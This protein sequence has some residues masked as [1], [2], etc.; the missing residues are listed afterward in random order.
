MNKTPNT[1]T[2]TALLNSLGY[3]VTVGS[4]AHDSHHL[5]AEL[6]PWVLRA[7]ASSE[8]EGLALLVEQ[9]LGHEACRC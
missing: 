1:N 4:L 9:A 3:T 7:D 8:E 5:T 6:G 2:N